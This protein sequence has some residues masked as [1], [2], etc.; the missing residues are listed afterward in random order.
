MVNTGRRD[1]HK[2]LGWCT[3]GK[4]SKDE[5]QRPELESQTHTIVPLELVLY[6]CRWDSN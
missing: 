2:L 1:M 3:V 5:K 4:K 6:Y